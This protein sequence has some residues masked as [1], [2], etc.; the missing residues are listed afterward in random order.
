LLYEIP[1]SV[2]LVIFD[3]EVGLAKEIVNLISF[4]VVGF[5]PTAAPL[6]CAGRLS[7]NRLSIAKGINPATLLDWVSLLFCFP[8][9]AVF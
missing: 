3:F 9:V 4:C 8:S 6:M 1:L 5:V 7:S 2:V